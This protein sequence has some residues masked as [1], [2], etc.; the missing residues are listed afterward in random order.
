MVRP[1]AYVAPGNLD[2]PGLCWVSL[3]LRHAPFLERGGE[4][5]VVFRFPQYFLLSFLFYP[6]SACLGEIA[7][8]SVVFGAHRSLH[9]TM[10]TMYSNPF[11]VSLFWCL[12][13]LG[14]CLS[15]IME[16]IGEN[17]SLDIGLYVNN[18]NDLVSFALLGNVKLDLQASST[19]PGDSPRL[20]SSIPV[21]DN[22]HIERFV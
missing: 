17:M 8:L 21:W 9:D 13:S 7:T 16:G 14:L 4:G 1:G 19:R 12:W 11:V 10:F 6:P 20:P 22:N 3:V 2:I 15:L 18:N 5:V